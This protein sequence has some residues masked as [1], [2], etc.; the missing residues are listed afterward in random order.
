MQII[1]TRGLFLSQIKKYQKKKNY[2]LNSLK[3]NKACSDDKII[4]E[5]IRFTIEFL[6]LISNV[7]LV[8]SSK[9]EISHK[10]GH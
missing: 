5:Y 8:M 7:F 3:N 1:I 9:L 6:S 2:K 10:F 4:N